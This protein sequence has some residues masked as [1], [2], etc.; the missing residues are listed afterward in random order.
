LTVSNPAHTDGLS[1][2][3]SH[4]RL[5]K[6]TVK[7]TFPN[8]TSVALQSTQAQLDAAAAVA[9]GTAV[10]TFPAGSVALPGL[11]CVLDPSTG[12]SRPAANQ[13]AYS[14]NGVQAI[15]MGGTALITSLAIAAPAIATTGAFSGWL[16]TAC[17]DRSEVLPRVL[18]HQR[19]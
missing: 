18:T 14:I 13:L 6:S 3:D 10:H 9:A 8:F 15:L 17:A 5:I 11:T 12:W 2:A 4:M 1:Q 16:R 7:A 19:G